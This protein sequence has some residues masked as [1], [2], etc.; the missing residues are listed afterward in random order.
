M[1]NTHY[2]RHTSCI[3]LAN[4]TRSTSYAE[5]TLYQTYILYSISKLHQTYTLCRTH[6]IPDIRGVFKKRPNFLNSAPTSTEGALRLLS[7]P[8]GRLWQQTAI[9][10]VSL[11]A[12]VIELHPLNWA[13]APAVRRISDKVTTKE[14]EEQRVYVCEILLQTW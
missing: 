6:I 10:P 2:T 14:L 9:C 4:C 13:R 7:T 12:L 3:A 1:Q 11:W 8:S 5:H